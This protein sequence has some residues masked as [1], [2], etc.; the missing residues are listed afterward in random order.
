MKSSTFVWIIVIVLVLLGGWY[1]LSRSAPATTAVAPQTELG[2]QGGAGQTNTG[3]VAVTPVVTVAHDAKLGDYLVASN[4][5]TLYRYTKDTPNVSN[6]SG[7]CV[8]NWPPYAQTNTATPLVAS[9]DA[10]GTL[11][12]LTRADNSS[13]QISYNGVPLYFWK[14]DT[15]PGDTT[16][17]G[18]GGVWYVVKP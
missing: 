5:M 15:K 7:T 17:Q 9:A 16:G 1:F 13:P 11:S 10:T 12:T 4:G 18:V 8:V 2:T 14:N 6:C 3:Q